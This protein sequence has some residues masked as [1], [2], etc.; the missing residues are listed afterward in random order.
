MASTLTGAGELTYLSF[1]ITKTETTPDGDVIVYGK[2][3]DGSVDSDEQIVDPGFASK[4]IDEWLATGPNVRVQHQ[5]QRDPAGVGLEAEHGADGTWVKAL[6][7]EPVAQRLVKAGALRAYSV[8]IARPTIQR[9]RVARGGRITDGQIV[10][11]SLVDRPANKNCGIQLVKSAADGTP[12]Y[13]G[14]MF[15]DEEM[16]TKAGNV[17]ADEQGESIT[18]PD[19]DSETLPS[20]TAPSAASQTPL[21]MPGAAGT[22]GEDTIDVTFKM[23][24]LDVAK[25]VARRVEKDHREFSQ[26][27][28][29][30]EASQ[31][32]ALPD[33]S[34][35]IPDTDALRRAAILARSGHGNVSAAR[36]LIA[37]RAKELGVP[38]PLTEHDDDTKKG[39][40]MTEPDIEKETMDGMER[41]DTDRDDDATDSDADDCGAGKAAKPKMK[42]KKGK[43][44]KMPPWLQDKDGD[45]DDDDSKADKGMASSNDDDEPA[46]EEQLNAEKSHPT[47]GDGVTGEHVEPAPAHREP[48]G[49][50]MELFEA[51][52][53]MSDGDH[54]STAV[55]AE[56]KA[57]MRLKSL[58]VPTEIGM[59]HDLTC[60]AYA[61]DDVAKHYPSGGFDT[62]DESFFAEKALNSAA[63]DTLADAAKA[64]M[65]WNHARTLKMISTEDMVALQTEAHKAFQDANPG[66]GSA[67][68]PGEIHATSY[69]RPII[70][71]G[72]QANSSGH[73]GPNS[74]H[75]PA[76]QIMATSYSRGPITDGHEAPSPGSTNKGEGVPTSVDY[77]PT[78][79]ENERRAMRAM[80]DHIAQTFPD[81]CSMSPGN[82]EGITGTPVPVPTGHGTPPASAV[83]EEAAAPVEK[84][85]DADVIKGMNKKMRKKLG[86]K[87]L[88]GKMTV[89]EA[90]AKM[91]RMNSQKCKSDETEPEVIKAVDAVAEEALPEVEKTADTPDITKAVE[92]VVEKAAVIP[93]LTKSDLE[94]ALAPLLERINAQ[95]T[96]IKSQN[97]MI[98]TM[99]DMPD[100]NVAAF[101]GLAQQPTNHARPADVHKSVAEVAE[102]T[103]AMMLRELETQ[104]RTS[105]DPSQREAAWQSMLKM[106]GLNQ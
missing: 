74:A 29:E 64:T 22:K 79:K 42:P 84:S 59:L 92:P 58:G 15:G 97:E 90:R 105:P 16:I 27:T 3:T 20:D 103:Q 44:K 13:V 94:A 5:S 102:R 106:R 47:P 91:G 33:G 34:Y 56:L 4:A 89:D 7:V 38:N 52:A 17:P 60:A 66:P 35:P 82:D 63:M 30:H 14:K 57:A 100:P 65:L 43:G 67:P 28:R 23:S 31:D 39:A 26:A 76:G 78:I 93:E 54:E 72:H 2:A 62:I 101:K 18:P 53:H 55:P 36:A 71:A 70:T 73:D 21:T 6:V 86:K 88:A 104:F 46:D 1:P 11:I 12:E 95:E 87:V 75:V 50:Y 19:D 69:N 68:T 80:H 41:S 83:K 98:H 32:H 40:M 37:R 61:P 8:G 96:L 10:E 45:N 85:E 49:P 25:M 77:V 24:P 51:S 81:V 48:D 9:D 99:V